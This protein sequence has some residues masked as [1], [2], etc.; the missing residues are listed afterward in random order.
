MVNNIVFIRDGKYDNIN[1]VHPAYLQTVNIK[2]GEETFK[3]QFD[4]GLGYVDRMGKLLHSNNTVI[5]TGY[6]QGTRLLILIFHGAFC[7]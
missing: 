5:A 3:L 1:D 4:L 6:E 7:D 2:T